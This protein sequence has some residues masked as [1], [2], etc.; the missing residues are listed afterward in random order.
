MRRIIVSLTLCVSFGS[1]SIA[2]ESDKSGL[3]G[4]VYSD[5]DSFTTTQGYIIENGV[6]KKAGDSLGAAIYYAPENCPTEMIK[7]LDKCQ[8]SECTMTI[9]SSKGDV[10]VNIKE[11]LLGMDD[12]DRCHML[13]EGF[14]A[15]H[16]NTPY[17]LECYLRPSSRKAAMKAFGL[18]KQP[19]TL[20]SGAINAAKMNVLN[21][22]PNALISQSDA[23][24]VNE[25][26]NPRKWKK[27]DPSKPPAT[28]PNIAA[29][30]KQMEA[31][32]QAHPEMK[33]YGK[34]TPK[35]QK[36]M[37]DNLITTIAKDPPVA[38]PPVADKPENS[39]SANACESLAA[40]VAAC[41]KFS[42]VA[43]EAQ[44]GVGGVQDNDMCYL[45]AFHE[46]KLYSCTVK[47]GAL[48]MVSAA[49]PLA[50]ANPSSFVSSLKKFGT[51]TE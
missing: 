29:L 47:K 48:S 12:K 22:D 1:A 3:A 15:D 37:M 41:K 34:A 7:N 51:C 28:P 5:K 46:G 14:S 2:A 49:A 42:C 45:T 38:S 9:K 44:F 32:Q 19:D 26:C 39:L 33:D 13:S 40:S 25:D 50:Y 8:P 16:A 24:G 27:Y 4:P 36:K 43:G 20:L 21:S 17:K 31:M 23:A 11:S 6:V 10:W 18:M 30:Q 35:E